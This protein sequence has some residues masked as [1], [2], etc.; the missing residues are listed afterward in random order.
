[1][2]A[3]SQVAGIVAACFPDALELNGV[4]PGAQLVSC[5]IGDN[6][7]DSMETGSHFRLI[8]L[9]VTEL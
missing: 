8:D 4:A 6:R 2:A 9:C 5:K 1:M 3:F 7:L